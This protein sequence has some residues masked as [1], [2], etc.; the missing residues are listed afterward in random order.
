MN[1]DKNG[2]SAVWNKVLEII[3]PQLPEAIYEMCFAASKFERIEGTRFFIEVANPFIKEMILEKHKVLTEGIISGI[4]G[5]A[6][7]LEISIG[8]S[9]V[10]NYKIEPD[11]KS[12]SKK[13]DKMV[14]GI[15][16]NPKYTFESFVSG[17][18]NEF[19][20]AVS[21]AV[22]KSPG[23]VYNPLF[24]YG[25]VGLGKTHL[26]QAIGHYIIQNKPKTSIIYVSAEEFMNE[27]ILSITNKQTPAFREKYRKADLLLMD[28]VQLLAGRPQTQE[29]FFH[30]F[31]EL[32]Q[33]NKQIVLTSDRPPKRLNQMEDRL[34]N[35]FEHGLIADIQPPDLELRIAILKKEAEDKEIDVTEEM[36]DY[37]SQRVD[38]NI[39]ELQ[40]AFTRL[41]AYASIER[42][43]INRELVD[44]IL[45]DLI[46]FKKQ[47]IS[48]EYIQ[49][50]V[51]EYYE[52]NVNDIVSKKRN[53]KIA[54][55]RQVAI[56]LVRNVLDLSLQLIGEKFGGRDHTTIMHS[57]AKIESMMNINLE[58]KNEIENFEKRLSI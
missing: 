19:A 33:R 32:F 46:K 27:L 26:L 29:E 48:V 35:R 34:V 37:I 22:S 41:V 51:S 30:T 18:S 24:I 44:R 20:H 40:G 50:I 52:I 49:K 54:L 14:A 31:N 55:P 25:G 12:R 5:S 13:S 45:G 21:N 28:D 47:K 36:L 7:S 53:N 10:V 3:K 56:Y 17:K 15:A 9:P 58:F 57:I 16:L 42:S 6:L 11:P 23:K 1:I 38:S 43:P 8:A 2:V 39:R 4:M